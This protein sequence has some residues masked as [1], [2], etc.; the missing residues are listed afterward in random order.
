MGKAPPPRGR[1][2]WAVGQKAPIQPTLA[3]LWTLKG[4]GQ[5]SEAQNTGFPPK[6]ISS[7]ASQCPGDLLLEGSLER[8][9]GLGGRR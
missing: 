9:V 3:L 7:L 5:Y 8:A 1:C 4:G 2:S 6:H